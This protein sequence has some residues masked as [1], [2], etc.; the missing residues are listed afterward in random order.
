MLGKRDPQMS[1]GQVEAAG[2]VPQGH[3]LMQIDC[4]IDWRSIEGELE[5]LYVS[6][7]GRPSYPPLMMFKALLLQQWY[8]LSQ[9]QRLCA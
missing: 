3:F 5:G 1:F 4:K 2:W 7:R 6:R 8:G 9:N